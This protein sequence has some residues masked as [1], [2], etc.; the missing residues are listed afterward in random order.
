MVGRSRWQ[1]YARYGVYR[2]GEHR[3][4]H[5]CSV[6][7]VA[8]PMVWA[9]IASFSGPCKSYPEGRSHNPEN[10]GERSTPGI[11]CENLGGLGCDIS[12]HALSDVSSASRD[13]RGRRSKER[14]CFYE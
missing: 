11:C 2:I 8:S 12:V 3:V 13:T 14:G 6:A 7:H 10:A 5:W 1:T 4:T 9:W